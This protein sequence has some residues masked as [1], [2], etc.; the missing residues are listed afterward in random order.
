[1]SPRPPAILTRRRQSPCHP[2]TASHAQY[3]HRLGRASGDVGHT[4]LLCPPLT[5]GDVTIMQLSAGA[6]YTEITSLNWVQTPDFHCV[7]GSRILSP[8][9]PLTSWLSPLSSLAPHLVNFQQFK[10]RVNPKPAF[11][12]SHPNIMIYWSNNVLVR[13]HWKFCPQEIELD[14]G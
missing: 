11:V 10:Y 13:P 3:R 9:P 6:H 5:E 4:L 2:S 14:R 7:T 1:M 12:K 8:S